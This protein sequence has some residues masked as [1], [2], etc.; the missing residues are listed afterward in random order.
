MTKRK[1]KRLHQHSQGLHAPRVRVSQAW[2]RIGEYL[3]RHSLSVL[4]LTA[5]L[6]VAI[7]FKDFLVF[8]K[9]YLFKDIG[10]D[11]INATYPNLFHIVD[12]LRTEGI[13]KW[14]FNQGMGQN[15]FGMGTF[16]PFLLVFYFA[17]TARLGYAIVYVEALKILLG[18]VFFFLYLRTLALSNFSSIIGGLLYSFSGYMILGGGWYL[19]SYDAVCVALLL[20]AFEKLF[21]QNVWYFLPLPIALIGSYQPFHLYLYA[22]LLVA[23][24]LVRSFDEKGWHL[25][26]AAFL[27]L[28]VASSFLLGAGLSSLF[29]FSN[30]SQLLQSPRVGGGAS[31]FHILSSQP[32][33]GLAAPIQYVSDVLRMFSSDLMG[34]GNDFKGW[35]NYLES[36]ILYSGLVNLLLAPQFFCFLDRTRKVV[37]AATLGVCVTPFIFPYFRYLFWGFTGDYFRTFSFFMALAPLYMGMRGLSYADE[38]RTVYRGVLLFTL[39][40]ALAVLYIPS[41]TYD[42]YTEVDGNLR[43]IVAGFL[44]LHS[45]LLL[46][47]RSRKHF[48]AF[49]LGLLVAVALEVASLSSVTVNKRDLLTS[50]EFSQRI[51]YNDYTK[52]AVAFIDSVDEG[53]FRIAKDYGSGPAMHASLNDAKIQKYNG[54]TSYFSFNQKY[55]IQFLEAVD[56]IRP[57]DESSTR[58]ATGPNRP[59]LQT[60]TSVKYNLTK[61]SEKDALGPLYD[62]LSDSQDVHVYRNRYWLP[63]GFGYDAYLTASTFSKLPTSQKDQAILKAL[64]IEDS[65]QERFREFQT[66]D[67]G[68][69]EN[70]YLLEAYER[71]VKARRADT[72]KISNH[73]QNQIRGTVILDRKKLM[74]FSIPYDKG[75]SATIDGK[76]SDLFLAHR[77]FLALIVDKGPHAIELIFT[78]PYLAV[79]TGASVACFLLY[80]FLVLRSSAFRKPR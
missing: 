17:G 76:Q 37:Y 35:S 74:F 15:L 62:H 8:K 52:E 27:L 29:L 38:Q 67:P 26:P 22:I 42:K 63:L 36:P 2:S 20:Y 48:D 80:G 65:E 7:V 55:Y 34:T 19:F 53:F 61:R 73:G 13:P 71:D 10:S 43:L 32:V 49:R 77:G 33:F 75:W 11:S 31:Y 72:F 47:L 44:I 58:W 18:G 69:L 3:E 23:Y 60:L 79:G 59:V 14:S 12:Y 50:N 56:V 24:S 21:R 51:G 57:G 68:R 70:E 54:T 41:P 30:V 64:V 66:L 25:K 9:I 45:S 40:G 28:R 4:L 6:V 46:G 16:D 39:I 5:A 78:P 1:Q